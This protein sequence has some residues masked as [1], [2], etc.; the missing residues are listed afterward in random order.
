VLAWYPI[1]PSSSLAESMEQ[2]FKKYRS[3]ENGNAKYAVVQAEDELASIGMVIGASWAGARACTATSGPGISLMSEF[4]G[5]AYY[6]E[7]PAVIFDVQRVGPSTGLPTRTQQCDV[8]ICAT[9]SHGDTK[10]I[11]LFPATPTEC[12]ELSRDAFDLAEE[13]QTPVF[14]MSDLDL[15]MNQWVDNEIVFKPRPLKRGKVMTAKMLSEHASFGR[16]LDVDGDGVPYRTLPGTDHPKAA[17][18]TRG[19]GHDEFARYTESPK[20]Y[21]RNMD[22]LLKKWHTAKR[23]VPKPVITG[24][25][26]SRV[27]ILAYGTSHHAI[28][29]A[30]D[31]IKNDRFKYLRLKS[32]PFS[33]EVEEFLQSCDLVYVVEQN[34]DGQMLQLLTVD[35]PGYQHKFKSIR[36][37]GGFPLSA[38][39]IQESLMS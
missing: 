27:G 32:Y 1:T 8:Q 9:A 2:Y 39:H 36:Y 29:E 5:F 11:L 28:S 12:F 24:D 10:H 38:D 3:D 22:R 19:S 34:R 25:V 23:F 13:F 18:F 26:N 4:I 31:R 20:V 35:L 33:P 14:V 37:Y 21:A 6:T 16:Y 17:F 15:G 7:I 30:L